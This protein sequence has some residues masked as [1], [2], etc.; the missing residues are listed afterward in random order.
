MDIR[1]QSKL[2]TFADYTMQLGKVMKWDYKLSHMLCSMLYTNEERLLDVNRIREMKDYIKKNTSI[3]SNF[4]G[5]TLPIIAT[6]L[7]LDENPER[8]FEKTQIL[9]EKM[10]Q[11][12]FHSSEYLTIAAIQVAKTKTEAEYDDVIKR[13]REFYDGLRKVHPFLTS[14]D[15]YIYVAMLGMT[16]ID[17][18]SAIKRIVTIEGRLK[19]TLGGGNAMQALALVLLLADNDEEELCKKVLELYTYLKEKNYK[20]RYNG[21]MST[22]GVLAMT[23][24]SMQVIAEEL[25]NGAEYLKEKKGFGIFSINKVQRA[26]FSANF[27]ALQYVGDMKN[28]LLEGTVSTNIT[29]IIIAQ[30]MAAIVATMAATTAA[31]KSAN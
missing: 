24:S 7:S 3:F 16:D 28:N 6:I 20:L 30:Q 13:M 17:V 10:K 21:T 15:D 29:N 25:V 9:Y 18:S 26:M 1:V 12:G 19:P 23:S 22:L 2:D 4:K 11:Q 31:A 14:K 5:S 27:V 8:L